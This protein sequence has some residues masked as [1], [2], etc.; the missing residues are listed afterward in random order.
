MASAQAQDEDIQR[1]L[2]FTSL[3]LQLVP[4]QTTEG[5]IL[6]DTSTGCPRP[7]V[8]V[9]F[10]RTV[11]DS[12]HS[13]S[14]PGIRASL[15]L[16]TEH[17][18]WPRVNK[19]V[20]SCARACLQ[21][22]RSK[23]HRHTRSPLG[24]FPA[25]DSRFS[26]VHLDLVGPLPP[27]RGF[28]YILTCVDRFTRWPEAIPVTDC[29][30][31]TVILAFLG[32]AAPSPASLHWPIQSSATD[33]ETFYILDQNG[34]R[35]TVSINR[36]K[37]AFFDEPLATHPDALA[38]APALVVTSRALDSPESSVPLDPP[39]IPPQ[40]QATDRRG[41][42]VKRPVRFSDFVKVYYFH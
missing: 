37:V 12:L 33:S 26:H 3:H 13:L 16:V 11:F 15:N 38:Q 25:P 35:T 14:H 42:Q 32:R 40:P 27:S 41:R 6:C 7:L 31:K 2:Q 21:Y 36:L 30:A 19:N 17:F 39:P 20:R 18:F 22:Q 4:L 1:T 23:V 5:T 28:V 24:S 10:R 8:P 34:H 29:T 9:S